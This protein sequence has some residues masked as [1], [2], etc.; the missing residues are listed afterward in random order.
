MA[1]AP[2]IVAAGLLLTATCVAGG[3]LPDFPDFTGPSEVRKTPSVPIHDEPLVRI[4]SPLPEA[5]VARTTLFRDP[6][7]EVAFDGTFV[8]GHT[9]HVAAGLPDSAGWSFHIQ[10][11]PVTDTLGPPFPHVRASEPL[12]VGRDRVLI[13]LR[14]QGEQNTLLS[15]DSV[16]IRLR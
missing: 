10:R 7:L 14:V 13:H 2:R 6:G 15:V 9:L 8:P 3:C 1:R 12:L 5:R 16:R 11:I 4:T